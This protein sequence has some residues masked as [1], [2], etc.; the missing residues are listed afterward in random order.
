[1]AMTT[2]A[3]VWR[4]PLLQRMLLVAIPAMTATLILSLVTTGWHERRYMLLTV[5]AGVWGIVALRRPRWSFGVRAAGLIVPI[6]SGVP[7]AYLLFG[8]KGNSSALVTLVVVLTGLFFGRRM[9]A[10]AV[11]VAFLI[12][13]GVAFAMT[14]GLLRA[15]PR[16]LIELD[17]P[18]AWARIDLIALLLWITAG[19]AVVFVIE[20]IEGALQGTREA[21]ASL[22]AE[23]RQRQEAESGRQRAQEALVRAQRTELVSQLAA[24]VAHDFNNVLS[25]LS[26]WSTATLRESAS[27]HDRESARKGVASALRQG[28][29]LTRQLTILARPDR[30]TVTRFG[31]DRPV[32]SSVETLQP[33]MPAGIV[34]DFEALAAPEVAAEETEIQQVI[35][36]LVLNARDAMPAGGTIRVTTGV[37]ILAQPLDVAGGSLPPGR[38]ATLAVGDSG[39]GVEPALGERIFELFF[40]TKGAEHGTGLGL[41][42]VVRIAKIHGGGVALTTGPDGG[43]IFTVYLP[44][45]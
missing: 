7:V 5:P 37:A 2:D 22:E 35:Y 10:A 8:F 33:A 15:D 20:R 32:A 43:A 41:P 27:A 21:L 11:L 30:R 44:C 26:S 19:S 16:H 23:Q 34:L 17:R 18:V 38:W 28:Q 40:T 13:V 42:T 6:A 29:A 25:V 31:L 45:A 4:E 39:P 14:S 12:A 36:N 24:G 1:M 3:R 9:M